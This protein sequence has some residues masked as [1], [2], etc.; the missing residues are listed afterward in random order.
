MPDYIVIINPVSGASFPVLSVFARFFNQQKLSWE[1]RIT[2]KKGDATFFAKEAAA[3]K[4]PV[5]MYGGDGTVME[6][7]KALIGSGV[8]LTIIPGG[9]ANVVARELNIPL[10]IEEALNALL[11]SKLSTTLIDTFTVNGRNF[12]IRVN[13]GLFARFITATPRSQKDRYGSLAYTFNAIKSL[14][15]PLRGKFD[16]TIDGKRLKVRGVG[17]MV[18]NIAQ[19]GFSNLVWHPDINPRDGSLDLLILKQSDFSTLSKLT[20]QTVT[21][22]GDTALFHRKCK[23][24]IVKTHPLLPIVLDDRRSHQK[25]LDII[26]NPKS[27]CV[28]VPLKL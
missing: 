7:A 5:V 27:L 26:I 28:T 2:L 17:L 10:G 25:V 19:V 8:P 24:I 14:K 20:T 16:L 13:L 23:H 9:T 1:P 4:I 22:L 12:I 3:G 11:V 15:Q 18:T 21:G 6:V